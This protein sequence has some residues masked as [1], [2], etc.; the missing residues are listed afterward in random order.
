MALSRNEWQ[1]STRNI[2]FSCSEVQCDAE[3]AYYRQEP[4]IPLCHAAISCT[5]I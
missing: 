4:D 3:E 1:G 5:V 2:G